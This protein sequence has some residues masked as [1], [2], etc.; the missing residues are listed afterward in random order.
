VT[1]EFPSRFD[2]FVASIYDAVVEPGRWV[3]ALT[4]LGA[5]A[6]ASHATL[7]D[8]DPG[9]AVNWTPVHA[10]LDEQTQRRYADRYAAMDPRVSLGRSRAGERWHSDAETF[11]ES[12]RSQDRFY[13]EFLRP[14]GGGESLMAWTAADGGRVAT[15]LLVRDHAR[16]RLPAEERLRLGLALPHLDRAVRL[17]RRMDTLSEALSVGK[18]MLDGESEAVACVGRD[19]RIFMANAA[20]ER[21]LAPGSA[22]TRR[23]DRLVAQAPGVQK[24]LERAIDDACD[25]AAGA[26]RAAAACPVVKLQ[27]NG[28]L[29]LVISVVP[30]VPP[31]S[32]PARARPAALLKVSDPMAPPSELIMQ[33]GFGLTDAETRLARGLFEGE[34]LADLATRFNLSHNTVKSQMRSVFAKTG[35]SSRAN[36]LVLLRTLPR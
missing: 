27:Q 34:A 19:R 4:A 25:V 32:G 6:D 12:F 11:T 21:V 2:R 17:M 15:I 5:L 10:G 33:R 14:L 26:R 18:A 28:H 7:I 20:F 1:S 8:I 35:V 13:R 23:N 9:G 30:L 31:T 29:P 16:G 36:L 22:L 24:A 3:E